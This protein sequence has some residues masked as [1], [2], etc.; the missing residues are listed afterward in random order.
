MFFCS[1][2]LKTVTL[3]LDEPSGIAESS[4]FILFVLQF[5]T[6]ASPVTPKYEEI[7]CVPYRRMC[8]VRERNLE[9]G[10][11]GVT[12]GLIVRFRI[13]GQHTPVRLDLINIIGHNPVAPFLV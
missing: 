5:K 12:A 10:D 13:I 3:F 6:P 2:Y 8:A 4:V 9:Y 1:Y 7:S 11:A